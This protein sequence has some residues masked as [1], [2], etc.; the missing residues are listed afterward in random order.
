MYTTLMAFRGENPTLSQVCSPPFVVSK[1]LGGSAVCA[2]VLLH[3]HIMGAPLFGGVLSL[4]MFC[5]FC[6]ASVMPR[7]EGRRREEFQL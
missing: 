3:T 4:G 6:E 2:R 5:S 1:P 7:A